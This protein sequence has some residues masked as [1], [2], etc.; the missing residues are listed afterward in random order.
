MLISRCLPHRV[1]L[2]AVF[3]GYVSSHVSYPIS[4]WLTFVGVVAI[5]WGGMECS[6]KGVDCWGG[7]AG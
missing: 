4:G 6:R 7:C 1:L 2:G 5:W 3:D